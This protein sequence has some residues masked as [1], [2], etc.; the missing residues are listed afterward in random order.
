MYKGFYSCFLFYY[1]FQG[2]R[3]GELREGCE[4]V[5]WSL[6]GSEG[7]RSLERREKVVWRDGEV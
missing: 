7:D 4:R 3:V 2:E 6:R 5:W 1:K